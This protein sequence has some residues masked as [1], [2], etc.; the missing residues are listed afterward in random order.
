MTL[1]CLF[2]RHFF[3]CSF[4]LI[5]PRVLKC[6][7]DGYLKTGKPIEL[8]SGRLRDLRMFEDS[9]EFVQF[10]KN[11]YGSGKEFWVAYE[12][13]KERETRLAMGAEGPEDIANRVDAYLK[14]VAKAMKSYTALHPGRRVVVWA[15]SHY[16]CISPY[17]KK[18]VAQLNETD[19]L[20]NYFPIEQGGG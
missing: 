18:Q 3:R 16:D 6:G 1:L 10:L 15:V 9:P 13:A 19:F 5:S 20:D 12:V 4:E 14:V 2:F 17:V 7:R 8:S 11:K